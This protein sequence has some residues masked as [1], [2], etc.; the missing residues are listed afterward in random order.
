MA[1]TNRAQRRA[2]LAKL[3]VGDAVLVVGKA[4]APGKSAVR[5]ITASDRRYL[6]VGTQKYRRSDGWQADAQGYETD[7]TWIIE[8]ADA[9]RLA[10]AA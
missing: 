2:E 3:G 6:W 8:I 5:T 4:A 7:V 1:P 9:P 10:K